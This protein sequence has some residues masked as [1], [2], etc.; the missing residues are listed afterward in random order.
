MLLDFDI[1]VSDK[2]SSF[3]FV[4]Q[5]LEALEDRPLEVVA[6]IQGVDGEQRYKAVT[7]NNR[8][9]AVEDDTAPTLFEIAMMNEYG[10]PFRMY[11]IPARPAFRNAFDLKSQRYLNFVKDA[12]NKI[13]KAASGSARQQM[14]DALAKLGLK[15]EGDIKRSIRDLGDP[16]NSEMTIQFKGSA[17]PLIDSGRYRQSVTSEVR[18]IESGKG[19][20]SLSGGK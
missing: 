9:V 14:V 4:T 12:T 2:N 1:E 16:P 20:K 17:N 15:M 18:D 13:L 6:G 19:L 7:E 10:A 3:R 11:P 5:F 8:R